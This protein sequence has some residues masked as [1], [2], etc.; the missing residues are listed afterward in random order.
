MSTSN[1]DKENWAISFSLDEESGKEMMQAIE[2][3]IS[4]SPYKYKKD[5]WNRWVHEFM[6]LEKRLGTS[7]C[8]EEG[9]EIFRIMKAL[10]LEEIMKIAPTENRDCGQMM[11]QLI[12]ESLHWRRIAASKKL[13]PSFL[14]FVSDFYSD[15]TEN[16]S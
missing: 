15:D 7:S 6:S 9:A 8:V 11:K 14:K 13:H 2:E 12:E 5:Y 1:S 10:P 4:N 3:D 16:A